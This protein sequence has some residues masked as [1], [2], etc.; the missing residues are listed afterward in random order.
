M[1]TYDTI[2]RADHAKALLDN[3]LWVETST[4]LRKSLEVQRLAVKPTDIDGQT[5]LI[6]AEQ[7]LNQF[8][9]YLRHAIQDGTT[10]QMQ[11]VTPQ[12]FRER[13]FAR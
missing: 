4:A 12:T 5:K 13:V 9:T 3:P 11:L 8:E 2:V 10:A 1:E 7:V 6:L